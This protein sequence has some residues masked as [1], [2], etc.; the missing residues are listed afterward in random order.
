MSKWY[1]VEVIT[2]KVFAV[3]VEDDEDEDDAM[4]AARGEV[5]DVTEIKCAERLTSA[6]I[7]SLKRHA[8]EILSLED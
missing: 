5:W 4:D 8:D 7:D 1:E 3:E 6:D 2:V